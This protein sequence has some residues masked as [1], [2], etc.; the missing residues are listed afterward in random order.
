MRGHEI[1]VEE[2]VGQS[3]HGRSGRVA[4]PRVKLKLARAACL[5]LGEAP[6]RRAARV[7]D[8]RSSVADIV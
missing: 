7:V 2:L 1:G 3:L 4:L 5:E 8:V 6:A